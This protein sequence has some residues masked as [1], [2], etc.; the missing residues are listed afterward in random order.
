MD[1]IKSKQQRDVQSRLFNRYPLQ[2]IG[3][4]SA[5]HIQ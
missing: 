5:H 1:D 4:F 3:P 2:R